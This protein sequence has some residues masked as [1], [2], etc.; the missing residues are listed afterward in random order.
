VSGLD[1]LLA[2]KEANDAAGALMLEM[3]P[4]FAQLAQRHEL[5]TAPRAVIGFNL[6][7]TPRPVAARM[8]DLIRERVR[9]GA[10]I[11][12]PSAGLGRLWEPFAEE[13]DALRQEWIMVE[14]AAECVRA[15]RAM[16]KRA[17]VHERD[18]LGTSAGDLGG[19]FD[20]VIMNPPFKQGRDVK[21]I[22]H[23]L[24]MLRPGGRL[25]SLCYNGTKQNA[26]LRPLATTWDVLPEGSFKA[27]G[28]SA[29]VCMLTI[30]K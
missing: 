17:A 30:D 24:G 5:G 4:R 3:R 15:V 10:R 16:L 18:F 21:H 29:S 22:R 11:L 13:A 14:E 1:R 8:A 27:E 19:E 25:V 6:F 20:A 12:E 9:P 7:Q 2:L 26:E 28:T 23:A